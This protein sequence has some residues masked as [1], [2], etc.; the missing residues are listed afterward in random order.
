MPTLICAQLPFAPESPRWLIA[1][2]SDVE[3]ARNV[4]KSIRIDEEQ[5]EKELREIQEAIA[6]EK[7]VAPTTRASLLA[8]LK[9][10]IIRKRLIIVF[11]INIGQQLSG[12]GTLNN[13]S[14]I[15][16]RK[17]FVNTDT[18]NLINALNATFAIIFTLNA[19]WTVD[20]YGRRFLFI[21]GAIGMAICTMLIPTIGLTTPDTATG[22][23]SFSVGVAITFLAFLYAF[24]YKP[25]WGATV[26]IYT[27]EVF[28]MHV[29]AQAVAMSVQMQGVANLIF[30]QFFPIFFQKEGL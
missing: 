30:N 20:R 4:L 22:G 24:F 5:L 28:P 10:K 3:G 2:R 7:E 8:L 25:S 12:Q 14:S 29:R 23:K 1:K 19:T 17:V 16:Y 21:V 15:I 13:Y 27:A 18:V 6:Y 26:W 11:L 9:D